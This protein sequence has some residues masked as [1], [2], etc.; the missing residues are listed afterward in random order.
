MKFII[1]TVEPIPDEAFTKVVS[2][3]AGV[4]HAYKI[5]AE[6]SSELI[7]APHKWVKGASISVDQV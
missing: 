1:N 5:L 4:I 3:L 6:S 7:A 2:D